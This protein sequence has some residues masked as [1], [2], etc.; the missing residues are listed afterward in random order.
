MDVHTSQLQ[1][2]NFWLIAITC[3]GCWYRLALNRNSANQQTKTYLKGRLLIGV[4]L[5]CRKKRQLILMWF[6]YNSSQIGAELTHWLDLE[7]LTEFLFLSVTLFINLESISCTHR[8]CS[9]RQSTEQ[10]DFMGWLDAW[11]SLLSLHS[12]L[13][14]FWKAFAWGLTA[15]QQSW[16][17]K[18]IIHFIFVP[19]T[20][21]QTKIRSTY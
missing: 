14:G 9:T 17:V 1:K 5:P 18:Q 19:Q 8:N 15:R 4:V 7:T 20:W 6:R 3:T 16:V 21:A 2:L 12:R 10:E 13:L 11:F